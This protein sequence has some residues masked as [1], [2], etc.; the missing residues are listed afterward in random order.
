[1]RR[2]NYSEL[3]EV[4]EPWVDAAED[5][6]LD[7]GRFAVQF[8]AAE[9]FSFLL[10]NIQTETRPH[11]ASYSK[12]IGD[13]FQGT[14]ATCRCGHSLFSTSVGIMN[15]W[16]YIST[17]SPSWTAC[18]L[19][20]LLTLAFVVQRSEEG[21]LFVA[22]NKTTYTFLVRTPGSECFWNRCYTHEMLLLVSS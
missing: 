22:P 1:M 19:T 11:L 8:A 2:V 17:P 14:K 6:G 13:Y 15:E 20:A 9:R 16:S 4:N 10:Q 3:T 12:G 21:A 7:G 18:K 5:N